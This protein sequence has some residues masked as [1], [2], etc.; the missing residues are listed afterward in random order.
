MTN[1]EEYYLRDRGME[2]ELRCDKEGMI[3]YIETT[4]KIS[5]IH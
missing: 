3:I 4:M 5:N 2:E 1:L